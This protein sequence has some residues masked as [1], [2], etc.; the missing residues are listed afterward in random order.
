MNKFKIITLGIFLT[1]ILS[2]ND[3]PNSSENKESVIN[4][5]EYIKLGKKLENPYSVKNMK[6][7]LDS[8]RAKKS[9]SKFAKTASEFDIETSHLYVKIEPKTKEEE[10]LLIEVIKTTKQKMNYANDE[11]IVK[12]NLHKLE[13]ISVFSFF[14]AYLENILVEKLEFTEQDASNKTRYNSLDKLLKIVI[15][16]LNPEIEKLLKL[17]KKDI[18]EFIE[19]CYLVRNLHTHKLGV[20]DKK[21]MKQCFKRV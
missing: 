9:T 12:E 4:K 6:I 10:T 14:E 20:A 17:I 2:C 7:A 5:E 3:E 1:T 8:V 19:F 21:F 18:F 11:N 16:E 13:F 15:N